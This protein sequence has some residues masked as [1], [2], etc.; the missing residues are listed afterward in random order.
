MNCECDD[1][2]PNCKN[3]ARMSCNG[4]CQFV[5]VF[6]GTFS[7]DGLVKTVLAWTFS[8]TKS[9]KI[10]LLILPKYLHHQQLE[11]YSSNKLTNKVAH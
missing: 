8:V 7:L 10:Y 2:M 1:G 5:Q 9:L 3:N 6:G 11:T 4:L